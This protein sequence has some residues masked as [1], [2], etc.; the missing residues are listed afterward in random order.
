MIYSGFFSGSISPNAIPAGWDGSKSFAKQLT[1]DHKPQL[2]DEMQR[3]I[4]SG[5]GAA[6]ELRGVGPDVL[7][8]GPWDSNILTEIQ[9]GKHL[10]HLW[11]GRFS[12]TA[13]QVNWVF[14]VETSFYGVY[15][16][17]CQLELW[18][19][20]IK[21]IDWQHPTTGANDFDLEG[22]TFGVDWFLLNDHFGCPVVLM[23]T[24]SARVC[25]SCLKTLREPWVLESHT[26]KR[27]PLG[28][29]IWTSA[30]FCSAHGL[31]FVVQVT[32]RF[33]QA[34]SISMAF[35]IIESITR[36]VPGVCVKQW[37]KLFTEQISTDVSLW[38]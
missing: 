10:G 33:P 26:K 32:H 17:T 14:F 19:M 35:Q 9:L 11:I 29:W 23:W 38:L 30:I 6:G 20:I 28:T 1:R 4:A 13:W 12:G 24:S 36:T 25:F 8:R 18:E 16:Y 7:I 27:V 5:G 37:V 15:S 31:S 22:P 21:P 3:I 2:K 34:S